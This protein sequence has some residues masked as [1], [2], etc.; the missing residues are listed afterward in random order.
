MI[1]THLYR[2]FSLK[3]SLLA[4]LCMLSAC[5]YSLR[6]GSLGLG[7]LNSRD[8]KTTRI[9]VP[10]VDNLSAEVGPEFV[11]TSALRETLASVPNLDVVQSPE[12]ADY[13]LLGRIRS[14]GRSVVGTA[15]QA[16]AADQGLGGLIEGQ[17]SAAD[18]Q[19]FLNAEFEL[20]ENLPESSSTGVRVQKS[21]WV[22]KLSDQRNFEA[23]QRFDELAGSSSAPHIN[24][25]REELQLRKVS[26]SLARKVLDQVAQDF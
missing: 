23:Y 7:G 8:S 16:S 13:L 1:L 24:R 26:Q 15:T 25:S 11:L 5:S 10:I 14:W 20:L 3:A 22:R 17:V 12:Q 6:R 4:F 21:L 18:I 19:V 9:Y 2:S